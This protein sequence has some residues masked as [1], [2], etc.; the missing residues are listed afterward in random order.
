M[1]TNTHKTGDKMI[2]KN[3]M[4]RFIVKIKYGADTLPNKDH[5]EVKQMCRWTKDLVKQVYETAK[6]VNNI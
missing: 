2:T 3:E 4:A 1:K 6:E 5:K